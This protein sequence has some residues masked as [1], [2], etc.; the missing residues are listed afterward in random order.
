MRVV[1]EV[2]SHRPAMIGFRQEMGVDCWPGDY[3]EDMAA[4]QCLRP[5]GI[6]W[7]ERPMVSPIFETRK[8]LYDYTDQGNIMLEV[9]TYTPAILSHDQQQEGHPSTHLHPPTIH[10][11]NM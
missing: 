1:H 7:G 3:V 9:S 10:S 5:G 6:E 2:N 8:N 4:S 11:G